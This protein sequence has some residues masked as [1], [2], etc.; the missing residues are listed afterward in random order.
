MCVAVR[1]LQHRMEAIGVPR[2]L[3]TPHLMG[4]TIGP[5]GDATRQRAVVVAALEL[6]RT[7][8]GP[9]TVV[10]FDEAAAS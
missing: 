5:V 6:L 3:V 10:H 8:P 9:G 7:A 1:A 4:R 2:M